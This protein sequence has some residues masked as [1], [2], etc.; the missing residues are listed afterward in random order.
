MTDQ[1]AHERFLRTRPDR[2]GLR[3]LVEHLEPGAMIAGV[4]RLKGGLDASTHRVDLVTAAGARRG[5]VVRRF[6]REHEWHEPAR[7]PREA[8]TLARLASTD[9]PA[10]ACLLLDE[11]G[12]WLGV[13]ALVLDLVPGRSSSGLGPGPWARRFAEAAAALHDIDFGDDLT[14]TEGWL[15]A[16][17]QPEAPTSWADEPLAAR[18]W[19]TLA[20]V[21]AELTSEGTA[22]VHHDLHP[23]NTLWSR[24]RLTGIVDWPLAGRGWPA[25]D[26]AYLRHDLSLSSGLDAG[27]AMAAA[28]GTADHPGWDLVV[29]LRAIGELHL[30]LPVFNE[31]GLPVTMTEA[32]DRQRRW[33]ER[34]IAGLG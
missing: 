33:V 18:L 13:P 21:T 16:W 19:P 5:I 34:A 15:F 30:W 7:L 10:P 4:R 12:D 20:A 23:G 26:R 9:V 25:Y 14:A 6:H 29:A 32:R 17:Q 8:A 24:G 27:D 1:E 31:C 3:A 2:H 22:L 11:T 28:F